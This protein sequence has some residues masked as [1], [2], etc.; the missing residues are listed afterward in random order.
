LDVRLR[1]EFVGVISLATKPAG[2]FSCDSGFATAG[3]TP[4]NDDQ[5][6]PPSTV[7]CASTIA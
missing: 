4:N 5:V 6:T 3:Y 2:Q 1:V 7:K